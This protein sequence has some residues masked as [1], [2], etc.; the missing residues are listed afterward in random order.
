MSRLLQASGENAK[1]NMVSGRK[2]FVKDER[3][4]DILKPLYQ[5]PEL[6]SLNGP[7]RGR[8]ICTDGSGDTDFCSTGFSA[9]GD[10]CFVGT[11]ATNCSIGNSPI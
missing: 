6:M 11:G 8:G 1:R 3:E 9:T 2:A 10:G 5:K 7:A 4:T